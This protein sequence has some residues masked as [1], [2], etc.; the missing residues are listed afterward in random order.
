MTLCPFFASISESTVAT[1]RNDNFVEDVD[2]ILKVRVVSGHADLNWQTFRFASN[3]PLWAGWNWI[4]LPFRRRFVIIWGLKARIEFLLVVE[5][6]SAANLRHSW[7]A[8][9]VT[10]ADCPIGSDL[11]Q[12]RLHWVGRPLLPR[13]SHRIRSVSG[14]FMV[15]VD[16][17]VLPEG[18]LCHLQLHHSHLEPERRRNGRVSLHGARRRRR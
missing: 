5:A 10:W 7:L 13:N 2:H 9:R 3:S 14:P 1:F 15:S 6:K 17:V 8:G 16:E 11:R 18:A 4:L 12:P